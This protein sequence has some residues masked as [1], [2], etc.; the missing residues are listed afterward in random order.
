MPVEAP[1]KEHVLADA[2]FVM[3][4]RKKLADRLQAF[5]DENNFSRRVVAGLI[6]CSQSNIKCIEA[7]TSA[8]SF[9]LAAAINR[10][11]ELTPNT[12]RRLMKEKGIEP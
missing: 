5:R 8:P 9:A 2:A 6:G 1:R 3:A 12:V 7:M 11:L 10:L 4:E